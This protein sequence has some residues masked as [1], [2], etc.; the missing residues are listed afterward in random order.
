MGGFAATSHRAL[1]NLG[2]MERAT[3]KTRVGLTRLLSRYEALR[4]VYVDKIVAGGTWGRGCHYFHLCLKERG[5]KRGLSSIEEG[6]TCSM[7]N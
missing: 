4:G 6:I 3:V 5:E 1:R 7:G 2:I